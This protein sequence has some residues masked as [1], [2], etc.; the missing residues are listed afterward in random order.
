MKQI[1]TYEYVTA[2]RELTEEGKTVSLLISGSSMSPFL[3]H[4][5]DTI[6][7]QKPTKPLK[8]G[9]IVFFQRPNKQYVLHRICKIKPDGYYIVGDNQT[10]IEGPVKEEQIFGIV[11]KVRRKGKIIKPGDFWWEFFAK[12]WLHII[13]CR[14]FLTNSYAKHIYQKKSK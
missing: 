6:F 5:R 12:V 1:D 8:V 13:P 14:R 7:F 9:D 4:H 2:L 3:I 10:D 11:T